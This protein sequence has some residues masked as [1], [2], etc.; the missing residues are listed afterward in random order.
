M[1]FK[2]GYKTI[3]LHLVC[4]K[5]LADVSV[6]STFIY[7]LTLFGVTAK[8]LKGKGRFTRIAVG[9]VTVALF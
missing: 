1:A 2:K 7:F 9:L 8:W 4:L 3:R 5:R 6:C